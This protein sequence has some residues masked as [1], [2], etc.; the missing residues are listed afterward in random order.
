MSHQLA[1]DAVNAYRRMVGGVMWTVGGALDS[2][3]S[4]RFESHMSSEFA[5]DLPKGSLY[6]SF[7]THDKQGGEYRTWDKI[8]PD[9]IY[10]PEMSYFELVV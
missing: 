10:D 5:G 7:V 6:D 4:L 2:G 8:K 9:F 3:S 1:D